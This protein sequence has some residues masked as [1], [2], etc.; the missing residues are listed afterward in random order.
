[1]RREPFGRKVSQI[2]CHDMGG[3]ACDRG[4]E[5]VAVAR[6]GKRQ[7][8]NVLLIAADIGCGQ[9][10]FHQISRLGQALDRKI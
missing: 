10:A 3:T 2:P 8:L 9:H 5:D 4:S 6:I 1:M 7:L